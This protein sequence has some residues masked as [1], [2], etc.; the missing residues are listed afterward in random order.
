MPRIP[1]SINYMVGYNIFGSNVWKNSF[2]FSLGTFSMI[3]FKSMIIG[4]SAMHLNKHHYNKK[5][6]LEIVPSFYNLKVV[7]LRFSLVTIDMQK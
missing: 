7:I 4:T 3:Q 1:I 2:E 6:D 5:P